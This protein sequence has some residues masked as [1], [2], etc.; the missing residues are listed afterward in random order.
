[1]LSHFNNSYISGVMHLQND[2]MYKMNCWEFKN[3]GRVPYGEHIKDLGICPVAE[4]DAL[5]NVNDGKNAGRICW[6]IGGTLCG[7]EVQGTFAAKRTNCKA[8]DFFRKVMREE[9]GHFILIPGVIAE[10]CELSHIE[11][12][13]SI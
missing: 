10:S 12:M 1:M 11:D 6:A 3:C 2:K 5:D 9:G 13:I 8:C 7:G 4:Y